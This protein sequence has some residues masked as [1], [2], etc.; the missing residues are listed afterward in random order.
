MKCADDDP[1]RPPNKSV[2]AQRVATLAAVAEETCQQMG[3]SGTKPRYVIGTEVPLPGGV[4]DLEEQ[5]KVT[6]V[7]DV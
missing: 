3:S 6:A 2:A 7:Q 1:E 5:M 4:E